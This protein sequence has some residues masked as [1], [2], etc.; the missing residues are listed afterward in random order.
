MAECIGLQV[1]ESVRLNIRAENFFL[2]RV[3]N[4]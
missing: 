1:K 2:Y 4:E 3:Q